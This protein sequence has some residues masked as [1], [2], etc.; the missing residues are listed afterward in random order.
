MPSWY[1]NV[2]IEDV[3]REAK[4]RVL[5]EVVNESELGTLKWLRCGVR[6]AENE[7]IVGISNKW[8]CGV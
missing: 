4:V 3:L 8:F 7:V 1:F 2:F 5:K 6:F